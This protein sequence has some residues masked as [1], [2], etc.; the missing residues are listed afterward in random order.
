[1]QQLIVGL[2]AEGATDYRFLKPVVENTLKEI[3]FRC[4]GEID[5]DV[6]EIKCDKKRSFSDYVLN[7]ARAGFEQYGI[8]VL[9]VHTDADA[10]T[11][12]KVYKNK[13]LPALENLEKQN[14]SGLCKKIAAPV[15]VMETESW[16]LADKELLKRNIGTQKT[17]AELGIE[18]HP[19]TFTNPKEKIENAIKTG[20]ANM[21]KKYRGN[22]GIED[23]YSI[24][25]ESMLSEKLAGFKSFRDFRSNI[26]RTLIEL[27]F[28]FDSPV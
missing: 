18:G 5:I 24:L 7:A 1:M 19:E 9:V 27:G 15:P 11:K 22:L 10:P 14:D 20:R 21:P 3:A 6:F 8:M 17:D 16:M 12:D 26:E 28:K 2:M 13:I 4:R 25:G 23:L